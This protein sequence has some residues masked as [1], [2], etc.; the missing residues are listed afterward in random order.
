[1]NTEL[2]LQ[3]LKIKGYDTHTHTVIY[4]HSIVQLYGLYVPTVTLRIIA[5]WCGSHQA[6][7]MEE[8][9]VGRRIL[10]YRYLHLVLLPLRYT[11]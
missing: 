5:V 8:G 3:I 1:M 4:H 2:L 9:W 11:L 6:D 10:Y 7:R